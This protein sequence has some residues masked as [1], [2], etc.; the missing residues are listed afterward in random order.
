VGF[1]APCCVS[2]SF[3][4]GVRSRGNDWLGSNK[5]YHGSSKYILLEASIEAL[6]SSMETVDCTHKYQI[7]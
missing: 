1:I 5:N 4:L 3:R 7:L 6:R 2:F